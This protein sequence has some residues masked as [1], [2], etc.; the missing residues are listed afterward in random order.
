MIDSGNTA[1]KSLATKIEVRNAGLLAAAQKKDE[2]EQLARKEKIMLA[3]AL[4]ARNIRS[5][6]TAHPPDLEDA[7][8]HLAPDPLSP[9]SVL[10][11]PVILLYPLHA[12]SDFIK[13]FPETDTV[14]QHLEYILPLPWDEKGEYT[15]DSVDFYVETA[16]GGLVK[17][18][19]KVSLGKMLG[20]PSVEVM[21][22]VVRVNVVLKGRSGRWIEEV[23]ARKGK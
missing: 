17:P 5:H 6:N 7:H 2:R 20:S 18:G 9:T 19:K 8:I 4:K 14:P 11:F 16:S 12:Q 15:L 23:K 1:L 3:T 22:G 13:A 10:H 21:D